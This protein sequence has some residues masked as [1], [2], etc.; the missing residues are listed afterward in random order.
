ML[1]REQI[2][3][4]LHKYCIRIQSSRDFRK[5]GEKMTPWIVM[6]DCLP[7]SS[8]TL[9]WGA[10]KEYDSVKSTEVPFPNQRAQ[11]AWI[12]Q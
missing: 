3:H 6:I 2:R 12:V 5:H 10:A 4:V 11:P 9:A 7:V 1:P 8:E